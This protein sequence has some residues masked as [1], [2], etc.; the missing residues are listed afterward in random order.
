[1]SQRLA[2]LD[3]LI[4]KGSTDP[5]VYYARAMELQGMDDPQA[6]LAA[7]DEV[8]KRFPAYV[9]TYLMGGQLAAKLGQVELARS[10][11]Q[12]GMDAAAAA[13]DDHA[14]SELGTALGSL[15]A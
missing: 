2:M 4:A 12:A 13:G 5:F 6:A 11:F 7:F 1:M 3:K 10:F 14:Q 15:P 8:R 9:P